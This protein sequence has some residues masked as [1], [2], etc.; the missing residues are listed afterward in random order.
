MKLN[1]SWS[2]DMAQDNKRSDRLALVFFGILWI[3]VGIKTLFKPIYF[4]RGAYVD[5][6]GYN[7]FVGSGLI[8]FGVVL[9]LVYFNKMKKL[10]KGRS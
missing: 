4:F 8:I 6:T 7:G 9:L 1:K 2:F 5:F 10:I 3:L